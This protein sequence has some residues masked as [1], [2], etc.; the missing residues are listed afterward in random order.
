VKIRGKG[1]DRKIE[2]DVRKNRKVTE[3]ERRNG[4]SVASAIAITA[5]LLIRILLGMGARGSVVG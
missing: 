1:T 4:E 5:A 2:E 3:K